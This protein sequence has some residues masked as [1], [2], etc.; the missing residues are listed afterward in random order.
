MKR[1]P[2]P[3]HGEV[4]ARYQYVEM[5]QPEAVN[6]P[7]SGGL[8]DYWRMLCRHKGAMFLFA[9]CGVL[10]AVLFSLPQ[11]PVYQAKTTLELLDI[12][13]NVLN[14]RDLDPT[15][16]TASSSPEFNIQTQVKLLQSE[17]LVA[18]ALDKIEKDQPQELAEQTSRFSEWRKALGLGHP[19]QAPTDE[20]LVRR[21]RENLKV[22]ALARTRLVEVRYDSPDPKLAADFLNVLGQE[23]IDQQVEVRWN[24][25]QRTGEWLSKQIQELK[26]KLEKAEDEL[27]QYARTTG[28]MF[29]SEKDSVAEEK[30][31]QVQAA[32][33]AAQAERASKQSQYELVATAA[34][35]S[36]PQTL[37]DRALA[38]YQ[39]KLTDL[40]RERA[41]LTSTLTPEHYKVQRV[42]A[43][44]AT[45]EAAFS[46]QRAN[47][48]A[49]I[50][51]E[52]EAAQRRETLLAGSFAAQAKVVSD[53]SARAVHY[54]ILKREVDTNRQLYEGML[55]KVK[56]YGIA[57]AMRASNVRVVDAAT[58][59]VL[60]YKPNYPINSALGLM[61]GLFLGVMFVVIRERADRSIQ[62]P[63]D[64]SY[65]LDVPELGTIPSASAARGLLT[66]RHRDARTAEKS[67][68]LGTSGRSMSPLAESFRAALTSILFIGT[69]GD[70]P[71][72]IVL[73]SA[74]PG[75]G[76]TTVAC[77]LGLALA[78]INRRVLLIDGDMRKPRLHDIFGIANDWGLSDLLRGDAPPDGSAGFVY[79]TEHRG[80]YILPAGS[81]CGSAANLLHSERTPEMLKRFREEFDAVLIDTPPMLNMPD[82]RV[83]G[84]SADGVI[85]VVRSGQ[86]TRDMA[87]AAA[88]RFG[89]DGTRVIGTILNDWNPKTLPN[90]YYGYYK[91]YD[92]PYYYS[93]NGAG[94]A[95]S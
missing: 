65:Y 74:N 8:V 24:T 76:K 79:E 90:G 77:N 84:R 12:N 67:V 14:T 4:P 59:P 57:S 73:T 63:G 56:E 60:P 3:Q 89:E 51:N 45:L 1:L 53:Q 61:S 58:P 46:Q 93:R 68:E 29:T 40:R 85:L 72:T 6:G 23:F 26:I 66:Y 30:L 36:L 33:S 37:D 38:D 62:S 25:T 78:E 35:E 9:V 39:A 32:L 75:E 50:R 48:V 91:G 95:A 54:N 80:L 5:Q 11:T 19:G 87:Q 92:K 21:A 49:R 69:N 22:T 31:M 47:V 18:L 16:G 7:G 17:T 86:T 44:I 2:E 71:R 27:Q 94:E 52:Y 13:E 70:R 42:D 34:P 10:A 43:Q 64:T 81:G 41:E 83:L 55:Q 88:Q 82:A 20:A 28:L 15:A